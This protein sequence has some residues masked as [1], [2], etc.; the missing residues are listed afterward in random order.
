M[1]YAAYGSNLNHNQMDYRCPGA[2]FLGSTCI[3]GWKLQ[4]N[5][6][7]TIVPDENSLVPLGI[8]EVDENHLFALDRYEGYPSFYR[9]VT[10]KVVLDGQAR[11]VMLYIM[12][13]VRRISPPSSHYLSGVEEGYRDCGMLEYIDYLNKAVSESITAIHK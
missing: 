10:I 2:K 4:F 1:L 13:D 9:K 3:K 6:F 11:E 8:W 7:L 5:T 12:N